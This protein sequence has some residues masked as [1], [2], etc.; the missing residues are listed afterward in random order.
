ML[1]CRSSLLK[2]RRGGIL[3]K[4]PGL[5]CSDSQL[6]SLRLQGSGSQGLR[7]SAFWSCFF[8]CCCFFFF[9]PSLVNTF[10]PL[11]QYKTCSDSLVKIQSN[12]VIYFEQV[13]IPCV[14]P[15]LN[16]FL[17]SK[18]NGKEK[19]TNASSRKPSFLSLK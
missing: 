9:T 4:I 13:F 6:S 18:L 12:V 10:A 1:Y 8:C 15:G 17:C 2:G 11:K 7:D 19:G 14:S 3:Q 16:Y 5:Q